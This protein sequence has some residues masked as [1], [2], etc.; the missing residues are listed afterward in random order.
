MARLSL[1]DKR[2]AHEEATQAIAEGSSGSAAIASL[3]AGIYVTLQD[4]DY[5]MWKAAKDKELAR[6]QGKEFV[7]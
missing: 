5:K 1:E 4:L 2:K 3:L 6:G 7:G